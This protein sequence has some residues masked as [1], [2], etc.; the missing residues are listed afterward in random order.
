MYYIE[1]P[2]GTGKST[3]LR[4]FTINLM[5]GD[6]YFESE[7]L[8]NRKNISFECVSSMIYHVT[9]SSEYTP[10]LTK[11]TVDAIKRD[12]WLEDQLGVKRILEK[13]QMKCQVDTGGCLS[14]KHLF[15]QHQ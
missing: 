14:I 12:E 9:Q 10:I 4:M 11:N 6:V 3:L 2:N 7:N 8:I 1:S 5:K 13:A 15:H